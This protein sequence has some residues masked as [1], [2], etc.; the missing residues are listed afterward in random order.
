MSPILT[1]PTRYTFTGES[2]TPLLPVT[3]SPVPTVQPTAIRTTYLPPTPTPS[4]GW[5]WLC[6]PTETG[7]VCTLSSLGSAG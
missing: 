3:P 4:L 5:P 7:W 2:M 1:S 6:Q